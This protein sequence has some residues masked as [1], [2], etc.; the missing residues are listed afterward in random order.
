MERGRKEG[1]NEGRREREGIKGEEKKTE[2]NSLEQKRQSHSQG[3]NNPQKEF[4]VFKILEKQS[5][6][7]KWQ[8]LSYRS[9]INVSP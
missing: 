1:K 8:S 3:C 2:K 9:N 4:T 6:S 7:N 5:M